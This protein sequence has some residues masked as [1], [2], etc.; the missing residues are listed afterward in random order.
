M[1]E[2]T[3]CLVT[4]EFIIQEFN[5]FKEE[6]VVNIINLAFNVNLHD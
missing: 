1:D 6:L 2:F 5:K 4:L 3:T